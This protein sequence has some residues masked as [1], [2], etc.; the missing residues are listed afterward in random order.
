MAG[1]TRW[2]MES[3]LSEDAFS[4]SEYDA[5][6]AKLGHSVPYDNDSDV[7]VCSSITQYKRYSLNLRRY[8]NVTGLFIIDR[9]NASR[10]ITLQLYIAVLFFAIKRGCYIY[11]ASLYARTSKLLEQGCLVA[12]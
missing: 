7:L 12:N 10:I 6:L 9:F 4:P 1:M 2:K 3:A 5:R 11:G 8:V